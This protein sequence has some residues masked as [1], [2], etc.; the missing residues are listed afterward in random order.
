MFYF[1]IGNLVAGE[2]LAGLL[3]GVIALGFLALLVRNIYVT[4]QERKG[5]TVSGCKITDTIANLFRKK[6]I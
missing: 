3:Q 2:L 4:T 6:D 5:C 1:A